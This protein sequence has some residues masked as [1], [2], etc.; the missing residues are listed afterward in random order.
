M[1]RDHSASELRLQPRVFCSLVGVDRLCQ[2]LVVA[3]SVILDVAVDVITLALSEIGDRLKEC[4]IG[5]SRRCIGIHP[6]G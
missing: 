5:A 1:A 6:P 2:E 4:Q 3:Q